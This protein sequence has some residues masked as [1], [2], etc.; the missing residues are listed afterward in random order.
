MLI[1]ATNRQAANPHWPMPI[2][3][4]LRRMNVAETFSSKPGTLLWTVAK[5]ID[6]DPNFSLLYPI[7]RWVLLTD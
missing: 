1:E 5:S 3:P 2:S 4:K 6:S 7:A